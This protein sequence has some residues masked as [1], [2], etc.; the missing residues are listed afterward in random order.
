MTDQPAGRPRFEVREHGPRDFTVHDNVSQLDYDFRFTR[1]AAQE[2]A[3]CR[4]R[5]AS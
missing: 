5:K 2:A 1:K 4:N 3:D